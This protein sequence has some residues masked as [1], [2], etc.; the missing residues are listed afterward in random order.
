MTKLII[1][2]LIAL[3]IS[4]VLSGSL[5]SRTLAQEVIYIRSDG[6]IE[7]PT[8]SIQQHGYLYTLLDD[9]YGCLIIERDNII[10]DGQGFTLKGNSDFK[11][12]GVTIEGRINVTIKNFQISNFYYGIWLHNSHESEISGN[13]LTEN[14][15]RSIWLGYS[16]NNIVFNNNITQNYGR[17]IMLDHSSH[18]FIN[19]NRIIENGCDA[20]VVCN[21]NHNRVFKNQIKENNGRG[22]WLGYS[23]NNIVFNNNITKNN[24]NGIELF[25]SEN[26]TIHGNF[27]VKNNYYGIKLESSCYNKIYNNNFINNTIQTCI[28]SSLG[29]VWNAEY[30]LGG[31]YWSHLNNIDLKKGTSQNETGSDGIADTPYIIGEQNID[32]YP[33]VGI[34][35]SFNISPNGSVVV[36]SNLTITKFKYFSYNHTISLCLSSV[37]NIQAVGFCRVTIPHKLVSPE[38]FVKINDVIVNYTVLYNNKTLS[39]IYFAQEGPTLDIIIVSE[40][41]GEYM[42]LLLLMIPTVFWFF[43]KLRKKIT[44]SSIF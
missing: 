2:L 16:D 26:N 30:C 24:V 1:I 10:V 32:N 40:Y 27:I 17:S 5:V 36:V 37:K 21:A 33:L 6:S 31:N 23:D 11:S 28:A 9:I 34:S 20:I 13:M 4:A 39:T 25:Y 8:A 12:K 29:N 18:N 41:C 42:F 14:T 3:S 7:P 15:G 38:Y 44:I 35:E 43:I 19:N 22:I